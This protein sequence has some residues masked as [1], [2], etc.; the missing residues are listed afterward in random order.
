MHKAGYEPPQLLDESA[1]L[2]LKKM[3]DSDILKTLKLEREA[4]WLEKL[5]RQAKQGKGRQSAGGTVSMRKLGANST[6]KAGC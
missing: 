2:A 5:Q 1:E 4:T 6:D 3:A